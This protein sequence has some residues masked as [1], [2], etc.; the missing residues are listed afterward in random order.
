MVISSAAPLSRPSWHQKG[1][2]N[3]CYLGLFKPHTQKTTK[4]LYI[5][6]MQLCLGNVQMLMSMWCTKERT[7]FE[8]HGLSLFFLPCP[9]WINPHPNTHAHMLAPTH[10]HRHLPHFSRWPITSELRWVFLGFQQWKGGG[11]G[12]WNITASPDRVSSASFSHLP[13]TMMWKWRLTN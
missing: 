4:R 2:M 11:A 12:W 10:T 9:H 5:V 1:L 7:H 6:L 8:S 3:R 13:Q